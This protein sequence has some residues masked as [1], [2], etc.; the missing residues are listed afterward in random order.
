VFTCSLF[1]LSMATKSEGRREVYCLAV[2]L[3]GAGVRCHV[4]RAIT[5]ITCSFFALPMATKSGGTREERLVGAGALCCE[6]L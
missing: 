1:V 4:G 2:D 3:V 6:R 5:I